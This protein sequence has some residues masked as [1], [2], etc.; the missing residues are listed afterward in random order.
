MSKIL[1]L[2]DDADILDIL[3]ILLSQSGYEIEALAGGEE[4]FES[5]KQ[6]QPD[7]VLMDV[8]LGD[9]DGRVICKDIKDNPVTC[10]LPVILI[11]AAPGVAQSLQS[12]APDSYVDKPFDIDNLLGIIEKQL[13]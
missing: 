4:I 8:M 13:A 5:I 3:S 1:I 6:F 12:G 9:L 11:S 7:L 10:N 2:D